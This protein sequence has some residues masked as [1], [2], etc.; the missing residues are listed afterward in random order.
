MSTATSS[1]IRVGAGLMLRSS[2]I[3]PSTASRGISFLPR[4]PTI[5][6]SIAS[7][8]QLTCSVPSR[9]MA[10]QGGWEWVY[11]RC[12]CREWVYFVNWFRAWVFD[13]RFW[14]RERFYD[15]C[16]RRWWHV[17]WDKWFWVNFWFLWY[18]RDERFWVV[19]RHLWH[20]RDER[21]LFDDVDARLGDSASSS[22]TS[23]FLDDSRSSVWHVSSA[24]LV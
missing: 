11:D 13:D 5:L 19:F 18:V 24:R 14:G 9:T 6:P 2:S 16:W 20:V 10:T 15:W 23:G 12:W 4:L 7:R 8:N 17:W 21:G 3:L 22:A 1:M